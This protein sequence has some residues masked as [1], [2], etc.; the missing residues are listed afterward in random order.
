MQQQQQQ[1]HQTLTRLA[2]FQIHSLVPFDWDSDTSSKSIICN[3]SQLDRDTPAT[4]IS[5]NP[6]LGVLETDVS[7]VMIDTNTMSCMR[8]IHYICAKLLYAQ[9]LNLLKE[10]KS[11]ILRVCEHAPHSATLGRIQLG[12][13]VTNYSLWAVSARN[14][15]G[16]SSSKGPQSTIHTGLL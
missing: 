6:S 13:R 11:N 9:T 10:S 1:I 5:V 3:S 15:R 4:L 2:H 8:W 14:S 12:A 16:E 7:P